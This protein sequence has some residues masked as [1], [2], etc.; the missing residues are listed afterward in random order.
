MTPV[1]SLL[2]LLLTAT[3]S[4]AL[5]QP[6]KRWERP[7]VDLGYASYQGIYNETTGIQTFKGMRYAAPPVG[8][9]RWRAPQDPEAVSGLQDASNYGDQCLQGSVGA[10]TGAPVAGALSA[11]TSS[12]PTSSEDCLFV[13][14]FVP[15][16]A[17]IGSGSLPVGVYIHGG[18]Y[19]LGS[20]D[21][22]D[23]KFC[24]VWFVRLAEMPR[25]PL[26]SL[27]KRMATTSGSP[28][29]T[30]S[31]TLASWQETR[32][33]QVASS[34]RV[35]VSTKCGLHCM[36]VEPATDQST[37]RRPCSGSRRTLPR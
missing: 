1:L 35:F 15:P 30:V 14:V 26:P 3:A 18:G 21:N 32:L 12:F 34:M 7:V 29:T 24:K 4:T 16:N 11:A 23:R 36:L 13:N 33:R 19:S 31:D 2:T 37:S 10:G 20:G 25:Q 28:S 5:P 8:D 17:T 27:R 22:S 6:S 9:L